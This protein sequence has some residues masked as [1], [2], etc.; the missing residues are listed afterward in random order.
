MPILTF[1]I[2]AQAPLVFSERRP[3]GQFRP[4]TPYIPGTVIRGALARKIMEN[5]SASDPDFQALFVAPGQPLFHNAY[6]ALVVN[7]MLYSSR[8]L[9]ATAY[10]C[11]TNGG[12]KDQDHGVFDSLMDRLC[13]EE[14][15]TIV[16]YLPRCNHPSHP[17][18]GAR[19]EGISGFFLDTPIGKR[20]I[21]A[22]SRLTTRV[23]IN[24]RRNVAAES[25]LYSPMVLSETL[26]D[27][28]E[29]GD[30][31]AAYLASI[32]LMDKDHRDIVLTQLQALTHVGSGPARG[33][34]KV[35]IEHMDNM[36]NYK[37]I[38][39]RI[40]EFNETLARRRL[41]WE[42]LPRH[43]T[44]DLS[45][46]NGTYFTLLLS[47]DAILRENGWT[48][49]LRIDPSMLGEAGDQ[50]DLVR[51]YATP[52]YRGG[53]NTAWQLPKDTELVTR[54]GSVFVYRSK[55]NIQDLIE[56]LQ[57]LE[58]QGI[59]ERRAEGFGQV[60][61]CDEFHQQIWEANPCQI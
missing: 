20:T 28:N 1:K 27:E 55:S 21:T 47:S 34:G 59:G 5:Q 58:E 41:L 53:W 23:A 7:D 45:S 22:T 57:S 49:T 4:C 31:P 46:S 24:R 25:M 18:E 15:K 38:D 35:S 2:T 44:A 42:K 3:D 12:F 43:Q 14:L 48:P 17:K 32:V 8:P 56:P 11:K 26:F 61:I 52:D 51:C 54:M 37:S 10:S 16:P 9:P 6:P 40:R 36:E 29:V 19:V 60:R 13:V 50:A 30:Q 39:E 33:F